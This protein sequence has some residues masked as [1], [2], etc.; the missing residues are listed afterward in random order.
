M[1]FNTVISGLLKRVVDPVT[2]SLQVSVTHK[3]WVSQTKTG[4]ATYALAT[5]KGVL[6]QTKRQV[7]TSDGQFIP[8]SGTLT[9]IQ[10]VEV[11]LKDQF[12]L[13]DGSICP[14]VSSGGPVDPTTGKSFYTEVLLG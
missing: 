11:G 14:C 7:R 4:V 2:K 12:V 1:A 6:D 13:P 9:F 8:V 5:R 10:P 3:M